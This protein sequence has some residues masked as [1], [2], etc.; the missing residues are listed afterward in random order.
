ML[1]CLLETG[2]ESATSRI[3]G[4]P[5]TTLR[6]RIHDSLDKIKV[7]LCSRGFH[8]PSGMTDEQW[9]FISD[10][11]DSTPEAFYPLGSEMYRELYWVN[12]KKRG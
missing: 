6:R 9:N 5:K 8:A 12:P 2:L 7:V 3:L 1:E 4:I 11:F 10:P